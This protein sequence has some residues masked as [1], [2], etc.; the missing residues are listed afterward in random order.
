MAT[1]PNLNPSAQKQL[2]ALKKESLDIISI[3]TREAAT[4][5]NGTFDLKTVP[6]VRLA[7]LVLPDMPVS[8]THIRSL[9]AA[10]LKGTNGVEHLVPAP[11]ARYIEQHHLYQTA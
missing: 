9:L 5:T 6:G 10:G 7:P 2:R 11:V 4:G 1:S 8:A 3:A